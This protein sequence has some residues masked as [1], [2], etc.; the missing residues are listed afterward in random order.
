MP[1]KPL[2]TAQVTISDA[3]SAVALSGKCV[4]T[5]RIFFYPASVPLVLLLAGLN[6]FPV[7]TQKNDL[8]DLWVIHIPKQSVDAG[9]TLNSFLLVGATQWLHFLFSWFTPF[10]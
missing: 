2:S 7:P 9:P 10:S 4:D 3:T 5:I 6:I 1:L 8:L